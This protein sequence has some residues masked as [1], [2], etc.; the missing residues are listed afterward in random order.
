MKKT[1]IFC[2]ALLMLSGTS[3]V[4]SL[5]EYNVDPKSATL[6]PGSTLISGAERSL[7]RLVTSTSVNNN[8]FRLYV[9]YWAETTYFD[10]DIYDIETRTIN[11][12]FWDQMYTGVLVNLKEATRLI[13]AD[14]LLDA[15][16]KANQKAAAEILTVYTYATLVNTFGNVPYTEALDTSKPQPKYD[17]AAT[18]YT[19]L[20]RRLDAAIAALDPSAQGLRDADLIYNGDVAK[21]IKFANSLKLRMAITIADVDAA[22]SKTLAEQTVGKTFTSNADNASVTF[23]G[24]SPNTNPLYE[25]L[26]QSGR[27]DFVGAATFVNRLNTLNDPRIS[28]FFKFV[29]E[30]TSAPQPGVFKGGTTG[31]GNSYSI[32]SAPGSALEDPTLPGVLLSYSEVEFLLAEGKERGYA[33]IPGT[34]ESHYNAAV[35]ASILS[36]NG[37]AAEA[38]AYLAQPS[39]AYA[40]AGATYKEKI[41]VQKWIALYD[42]P[43]EAWKEVRR[44]DSPRIIA[45]AGALSVYPV[46]FPYP[47]TEKSLNKANN[48]AAAGAIGGD[49]VGTKIFWDKF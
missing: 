30:G 33:A 6:V 11:R 48:S 5:K 18:I 36:F 1:L 17:D 22:R 46:R 35:T 4:D 49:D 40:T 29:G 2:S 3:C 21:W 20:F 7:V 37:T 9:Q 23:T 44:L 28:Y 16:V 39:V 15:K 42:Q 41:G 43:V 26:V 45:P 47:T 25:Q 27:N 13:D 34:A 8:P 38:A 24:A 10:E 14:V 12:N 32:N 19:D 31:V